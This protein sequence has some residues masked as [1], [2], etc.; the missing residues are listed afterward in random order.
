MEVKKLNWT[1]ALVYILSKNI[2][3][4]HLKQIYSEI[5]NLE[6]GA[7][8]FDNYSE[9]Y[10]ASARGS[11]ERNSI[12]TSHGLKDIFINNKIGEGFWKLNNSKENMDLAFNAESRYLSILSGYENSTV[13]N[14]NRNNTN[15][16][17]KEVSSIDKFDLVKKEFAE[18]E[19]VRKEVLL[20]K[21]SSKINKLKKEFLN[22]NGLCEFCSKNLY[23]ER[24]NINI[25]KSHHIYPV[26]TY[27]EVKS[28][29]L[30]DIAFICADCHS[31]IHSSR[32]VLELREI[33]RSNQRKIVLNILQN[34]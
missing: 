16:N 25:A 7:L 27:E 24:E 33:D 9:N 26:S 13:S 4:L 6:K 28:T 11:L 23:F 2:D 15:K 14:N 20:T 34:K 32:S 30:D 12:N 29:S 22:T 19:K 8:S 31:I 21:R 3:G 18:G 10:E 1:E 5:R 17:D